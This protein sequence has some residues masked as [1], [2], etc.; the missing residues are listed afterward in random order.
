M[1][2]MTVFHITG[3]FPKSEIEF[4]KRF[5]TENGCNKNLFKN[6]LLDNK[7]VVTGHM[8][9]RFRLYYKLLGMLLILGLL[10]LFWGDFAVS[11]CWGSAEASE[12]PVI[13]LKGE[14]LS[15]KKIFNEI[16]HKT[17]YKILFD[18]DEV[19]ENAR[20]SVNWDN[21]SLNQ[22]VREIVKKAGVKNFAIVTDNGNRTLKVINFDHALLPQTVPIINSDGT[23]LTPQQLEALHER[24]EKKIEEMRNNPDEIVIPPQGDQ[25]GM[26]RRQLQALHERQ[27]KQIEQNANNPDAIAVPASED[28][29]ALTKRELQELHKQQKNK[30]KM[31]SDK[32]GEAVIQPEGD[33][34]VDKKPQR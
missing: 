6:N 21:Q 29:P 14:N 4:G 34:P 1:S 17:G 31:M 3:D 25:P 10:N 12:F 19:S 8:F 32:S 18:V 28:Q 24:Q 22:S 7:A 27:K 16:Q 23:G 5:V 33:H 15:L 26:T 30:L 9:W 11:A 20:F 13:S 2:I